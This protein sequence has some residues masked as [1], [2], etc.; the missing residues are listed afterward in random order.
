M[1]STSPA[2]CPKAYCLAL[3]FR[4]LGCTVLGFR[5]SRFTVS[6]AKG[7]VGWKGLRGLSELICGVPMIRAIVGFML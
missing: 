3:R 1:L 5:V 4:V 7:V 2:V 6:G